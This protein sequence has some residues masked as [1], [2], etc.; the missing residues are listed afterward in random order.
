[1]TA[2]EQI[3][4][5]SKLGCRFAIDDF[6]AGYSSYTYL[7]SLPVDY[8]KIDGSFIQNLGKDKVDQ[9]IVNSICHIAKATNK[10]TIAEHVKDAETFRVL[11][12]L[13]V[14][15]AQGHYV[16]KPAARP[17]VKKI[18]VPIRA[19]KGRRKAS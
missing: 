15:F 3:S 14:D 10:K 5:I 9:T 13:G 11:H 19:A 16:G 12:E 4:E 18:A 7:K 6:G 17:A 8:I 2:A 1:M